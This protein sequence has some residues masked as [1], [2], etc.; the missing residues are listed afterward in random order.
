MVLLQYSYH[1]IEKNK[2]P[3]WLPTLYLLG[4][5]DGRSAFIH[6]QPDSASIEVI[7]GFAKSFSGCKNRIWEALEEEKPELVKFSQHVIG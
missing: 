7:W 6:Q 3:T 2:R 4:G 1:T 5:F